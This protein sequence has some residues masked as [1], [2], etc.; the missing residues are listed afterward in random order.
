MF[1]VLNVIKSFWNGRSDSPSYSSRQ[2]QVPEIAA[3][4]GP[5]ASGKTLLAKHVAKIVPGWK[6]VNL[7]HFMRELAKAPEANEK[8][9]ETKQTIKQELE[10]NIK[11]RK[12]N[13]STKTSKLF[14]TKLRDLLSSEGVKGLFLDGFMKTKGLVDFTREVFGKLPTV[15][16]IDI[17]SE[18]KENLIKKREYCV[19]CSRVYHPDYSFLKAGPDGKCTQDGKELK[20]RPRD[21]SPRSLLDMKREKKERDKV[22]LYIQKSLRDQG[23]SLHLINVTHR[24]KDWKIEITD[25]DILAG[26]MLKALI[27]EELISPEVYFKYAEKLAKK[28]KYLENENNFSNKRSAKAA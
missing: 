9:E 27:D 1:G 13:L 11:N 21:S 18:I 26:V 16:S 6:H 8:I 4:E 24:T 5:K 23:R 25:P 20:K 10:S 2:N 14:K 12:F 28:G 17:P 7:K 22:N 3:I 19:E 15:L